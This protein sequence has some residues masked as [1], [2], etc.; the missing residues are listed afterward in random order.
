MITFFVQGHPV[1]WQR[2]GRSGFRSYTPRKTMIWQ[3]TIAW[4]AKPHRP[5][6]LM[7]G[8]LKMELLFFFDRPKSIKKEVFFAIGKSDIDNYAKSVM[9]ALHNIFYKNDNQIVAIEAVKSYGNQGNPGVSIS[10]EEI[11]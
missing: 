5:K 6:E 10:V 7:I 3:T 2:A 4:A 11:T 9:D 8:P 1:A